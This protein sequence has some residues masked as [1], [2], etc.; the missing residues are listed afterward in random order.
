M[1]LTTPVPHAQAAAF[2]RDK[3]VTTRAVFDALA[4]ELQARA[5]LI[6]GVESID[7]IARVRELTARLPEGGDFQDLKHSI[8]KDIS[9]W[10]VTA[11][12]P[13]EHAKQLAAASRRAEL[14]LRHHGHQSYSRAAFALAEAHRDTFPYRQYISSNDGH[15]RPSHAALNNKIL[16]ADHPFWATHTP[17]WEFNCHCDSVPMLAEEV[18]E[19]RHS[20][21]HLP[22]EDRS[23]MPP[24]QLREIEQNSRIL[25]PG[26]Q[27][28]L[29][30]RTPRQRTGTGYEWRPKEDA[31]SIDQILER[32]SPAERDAFADLAK[33]QTLEDG[34]SLFD[35]WKHGAAGAPAHSPAN[36][37]PNP[38]H[39]PANPSPNPGHA[40]AAPVSAA[41]SPS[42]HTS[43]RHSPPIPEKLMTVDAFKKNA[44]LIAQINAVSY[45]TAENWLALIGGT[46][47]FS[48]DD[49][50]FVPD[51]QGNPSG[52]IIRWPDTLD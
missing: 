12:E 43:P 23:V 5:F 18:D 26:A 45:A 13:E 52:T 48:D 29:D 42:P 39:S 49:H 35:W 19:I 14:L 16:P 24:A 1:F 47:V 8:L 21:Q 3:P 10:L 28:F 41:L 51:D 30:L 40:K 11:T 36:P 4:P 22:P 6:T 9:P 34:R 32:F 50:V 25:R 44:A 17:P 2:I 46:P 31:L 15:V 38:G 27:G 33:K 20:E 37:S 7:C